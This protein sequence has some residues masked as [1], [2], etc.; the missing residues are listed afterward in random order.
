[1]CVYSVHQAL[2][3]AL[4]CLTI[5]CVGYQIES[6]KMLHRHGISQMNQNITTQ[7]ST[8]NQISASSTQHQVLGRHLQVEPSWK[9]SSNVTGTYYYV[10]DHPSMLLIPAGC[11][12]R[13]S[14]PHSLLAFEMARGVAR[15][16]HLDGSLRG[17]LA[18]YYS[19]SS[20]ITTNN[21]SKPA[22][23][24]TASKITTKCSYRTLCPLQ[25]DAVH[26][27]SR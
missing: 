21:T 20:S 10:L 19:T 17:I 9:P 15:F 8:Q 3:N 5:T 16:W 2:R 23:E 22:I 14:R 12:V 27:T 1:M 26:R 13:G 18:A 4:R 25:G 11:Q 24:P 7:L 6:I